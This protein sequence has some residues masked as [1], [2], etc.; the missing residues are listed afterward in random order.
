MNR[1]ISILATLAILATGVYL[2]FVSPQ[3]Q[4]ASLTPARSGAA[5]VNVKLP[6]LTGNQILGETAYNGTC[7]ACHGPSGAGQDGVAPPLV[8]KIYEPNHHADFSFQMAVQNGAQ[9]H[10]WPFGNMPPQSGLTKSDV[11][12]I[13]AYVRALQRANGIQ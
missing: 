1:S 4:D 12:N 6:T 3:E 8:H 2:I 13:I 10:H 7:A 11:A 9:A 5:M